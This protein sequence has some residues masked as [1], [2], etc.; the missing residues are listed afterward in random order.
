M[1]VVIIE[2]EELNAQNLI[3]HLKVIGGISIVAMLDSIVESVEW[4]NANDVPDLVFMD[5]HLA[6]GSA[7]KIFEHVTISCP[8]VFTTAYDEYAL[9][10]F[11]V[12]SIDYLLKPIDIE[13]VRQALLKFH[14]L[15]SGD[16]NTANLSKLISTIKEQV[17]YKTNFLVPAKGD[18]L[19]PLAVENIAFIYI[20]NGS[21]KI[22]DFDERSYHL[23][24]T[25]DE[26]MV[27][28]DPVRFFRANRQFIIAHDA[29]KDI[30]LWFNSR[31]SINL[32]VS[33]PTK[34]IV[35]RAKSSELIKWFTNV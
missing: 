28:L 10:A 20:D 26:I 17:H 30:D 21:A 2:D 35:S 13:A 27:N 25:L 6:D 32:R 24:Q 8:I 4:F 31:L 11:K 7:F 12:N 29:V 9:K 33:V 19:I 16:D 14:T 1:K 15:T 3:D 5:I 22:F 18:K 34:I 23:D